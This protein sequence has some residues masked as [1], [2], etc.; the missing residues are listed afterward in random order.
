MVL[1]GIGYYLWL[2][3][4]IDHAEQRM[5]SAATSF[6][7]ALRT[8][9]VGA[10]RSSAIRFDQAAASAHG[11]T[12]SL[13][14]RI[15][16]HVPLVRG[17]A[18]AAAVVAQAGTALGRQVLDP[19]A[20]RVS[21]G[22][23]RSLTPHHGRFDLAAI[24]ARRPLLHHIA[25]ALDVADRQIEAVAGDRMIGPVGSAFAQFRAK[26]DQ[27]RE[28][29]DAASTASQVLPKMLG[30]RGPRTYLVLFDNNAEVR[31]EGGGLAG[32]YAVIRADHG[33]LGMVRVGSDGEFG[34]LAKPALRQSAAERAIYGPQPA[35][36]FPDVGMTPE[37]PR[38][39]ALAAA[40][41]R[42]KYAGHLDGVLAIDTVTLDYLLKA[43]GP[44]TVDG[45]RLT[46][47]NA[48]D[49][50]LSRVYLRER[51]PAAQ[52]AFFAKVAVA[53]F[54]RLSSG[55]ASLS[56]LTS[57]LGR[58]VDEG[59][60]YVDAFDPAVEKALAG[61]QIAG[62][63]NHDRHR[64]QLGVYLND[65]TGSKMSYYLRRTVSMHDPMCVGDRQQF[66]TT[67]VLRLLRPNAKLTEY[68][69]GGGN[70]GIPVGDELVYVRAYGSV[71]GRLSDLHIG[72]KWTPV[73]VDVDRGRPVMTAAVEIREGQRVPVTW[74]TTMA[75]GQAGPVTVTVTPGMA[76]GVAVRT[77]K[78]AC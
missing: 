17:D 10:A 54:D 69:T 24:A 25:G 6:E 53:M 20:A 73:Q 3:L 28:A 62:Q 70:Y 7:S 41:Y 71:G 66:T 58:S 55:K 47:A 26:V 29:A 67:T 33:R 2:G 39:A 4:S 76:S 49:Q 13:G 36:Y 32:A 59:R 78:P 46:S 35:T 14:W 75:S 23:L 31:A 64:P 5:R 72:G 30:A 43:T 40:M 38:T 9:D 45:H 16:E 42:Q 11:H 8:G 51:S 52:N 63:L 18:R 44:V 56:G 1:A 77:V 37:F 27:A 15:L 68:V 19:V 22:L 74:T 34:E 21:G 61:T 60:T 57:A 65:G 12:G 50:L 48:T